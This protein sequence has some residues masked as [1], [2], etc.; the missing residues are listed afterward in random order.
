[1]QQKSDRN[2]LAIFWILLGTTLR[3]LPHPMNLT[4]MNSISLFGGAKLPRWK[5]LLVSLSALAFSDFLLA[6]L[7]GYPAFGIWSIFTYS[8]F[9]AIVLAG[10]FLKKNSSVSR[11]AGFLVGSSLGFWLWTNFG[12]WLLEGMYPHTG[13]GFIDCYVMALPFLRN[14]MIG[15]LVSGAIFFASY[16]LAKKQ[17]ARLGFVVQGA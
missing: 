14:A 8:G 9:A 16:A 4:P 7:L 3:V 6:K 11:T 5:A 13:A 17:V 15:D 10:S 12:V 2:L 1:M